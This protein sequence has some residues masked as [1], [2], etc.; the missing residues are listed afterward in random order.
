MQNSLITTEILMDVIEMDFNGD[1]D[2]LFLR[3]LVANVLA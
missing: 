3:K 2:I 1:N